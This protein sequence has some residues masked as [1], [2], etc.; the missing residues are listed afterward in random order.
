MGLLLLGVRD[1]S[2]CAHRSEAILP[3]AV[4]LCFGL[5]V[6]LLHQVWG[7]STWDLGSCVVGGCWSSPP[8]TSPEQRGWVLV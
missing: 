7:G 6:L 3:G 2:I 8:P 4:L 5:A 1:H